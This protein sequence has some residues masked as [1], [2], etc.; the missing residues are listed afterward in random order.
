M[1]PLDHRSNPNS[2]VAGARDVRARAGGGS[3]AGVEGGVTATTGT[4]TG[5]A[6]GAG[7]VVSDESAGP[8]T[9]GRRA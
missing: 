6:A 4:G 2:D 5:G 7:K 3:G 8:G 1:G 9:S